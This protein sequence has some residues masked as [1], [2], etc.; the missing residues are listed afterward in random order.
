MT[1]NIYLAK[2]DPT[3]HTKKSCTTC[4]GYGLVRVKVSIKC[5]HC[6]DPKKY[7]ICCYC[8]NTIKMGP[9][10]ECNVCLGSGSFH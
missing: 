1:S 7:S 3:K 8:E 4:Q 9:Y 6:Y 5:I 10:E 2:L